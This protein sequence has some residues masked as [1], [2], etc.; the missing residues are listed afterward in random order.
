[1]NVTGAHFLQGDI[2]A[3]DAPFFSINPTEAASM[4]PQQRG[5][6]ETAYRAFENGW[7]CPSTQD[8]AQILNLHV[9]VAGISLEEAAGS[10]TSV[11]VGSFAHDWK[12]LLRRDPLM[13]I[14]YLA[15]GSEFS[16]LANRLSWFYD[17]TGPSVS[18]DTACSSSLMALHLACQSLKSGEADMVTSGCCLL[19]LFCFHIL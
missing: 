14:S 2:A 18:L 16:M 10:K 7:S 15:T 12:D 4:D 6:L 17:L 3:F 13:E 19:T 1:M 11:H 5:L 9:S 8:T